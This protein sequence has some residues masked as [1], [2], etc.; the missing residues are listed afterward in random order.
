MLYKLDYL[1]PDD[2]AVKRVLAWVLTVDGKYEQA[3]KNFQQLLSIENPDAV[4]MLNYGY[5]QW[6]SGNVAEAIVQFKQFL[7]SQKDEDFNMET[8]LMR[9][10]Y[11]LIKSRHID[12]IEIRLMLDSFY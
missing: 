8:E 3:G 4:D 2:I 1:Y 9:T 5:C 11:S 6:F 10:E 12:D 7:A